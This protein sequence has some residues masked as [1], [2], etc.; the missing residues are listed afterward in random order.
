MF[1][2]IWWRR[3]EPHYVHVSNSFSGASWGCFSCF[4]WMYRNHHPSHEWNVCF[5]VRQKKSAF[6]KLGQQKTFGSLWMIIVLY[7]Y[8]IFRL[9]W[10]SNCRR[11]VGTINKSRSFCHLTLTPTVGGKSFGPSLGKDGILGPLCTW[12]RTT[13]K[14]VC[15]C[16]SPHGHT[17]PSPHTHGCPKFLLLLAILWRKNYPTFWG[18]RS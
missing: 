15:S 1:F 2:L 9:K 12:T 14:V 5:F 10:L 11:T 8:I 7:N 16:S 17:K 4:S 3:W 13:I 6:P 18:E